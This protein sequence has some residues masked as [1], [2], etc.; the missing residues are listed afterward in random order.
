MGIGWG[1]G[2]TPSCPP[3][4]LLRPAAHPLV[5]SFPPL[6]RGAALLSIFI[7]RPGKTADGNGR[8]TGSRST[9][10][11]LPPTF[12]STLNPS[13]FA[14]VASRR[15]PE[16]FT[17]PRLFDPPRLSQSHLL[18]R[19]LRGS[20]SLSLSHAHHHL[21]FPSRT[22]SSFSSL[23]FAQANLRKFMDLVQH[24]QVDK[25]SKLLDRG[26]DPNYQDGETGG[27]TADIT[28]RSSNRSLYLEH[29]HLQRPPQPPVRPPVF[30]VRVLV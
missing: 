20:V 5:P 10:F 28:T 6:L 19:S 8:E 3:V 4:L 11:P 30:P 16:R 26:F 15:L 9:R 21:F 2:G 18:F 1:S 7:E 25:V 27:K 29:I 17:H 12:H 22:N 14:G 24:G 13:I 23:L